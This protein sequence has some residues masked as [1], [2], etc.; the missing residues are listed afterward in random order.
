MFGVAHA[1]TATET[2]Q[3]LRRAFPDARLVQVTIHEID[4]L[5]AEDPPHA[6]IVDEVSL[7]PAGIAALATLKACNPWLAILALLRPDSTL[8]RRAFEIGHA[9]VDELIIVGTEDHPE[10]IR[11]KVASAALRTVA[12]VVG[13]VGH[14]LPPLLA[15]PKLEGILGRI[16]KLKQPRD[17]AAALEVSLPMLRQELR[18]AGLLPPKL[19]LPWFRA[20][21]AARRLGDGGETVEKIGISLDY[22]S[23]PAFRHACHDLLGVTPSEI[24]ERGGLRFAGERFRKA[25]TDRRTRAAS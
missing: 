19:L 18:V 20:L 14:P 11:A 9:G 10:G 24:R 5:A 15:G 4:R 23:G 7:T 1:L 17:L 2:V 3:R 12:C 16:A 6:L 13:R 8:S 21:V 25:V 22:A